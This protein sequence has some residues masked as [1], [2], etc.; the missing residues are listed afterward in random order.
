M[1]TIGK[2]DL[3]R[4]LAGSHYWA[5]WESVFFIKKAVEKSGWKAKKDTPDFI[6]ALE[7]MQVEIS[8]AGPQGCHRFLH[9]P[10]SRTERSTS[11]TRS[12]RQISRCTYRR[13]GFDQ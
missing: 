9:E 8:A 2:K 12:L 4:I 6:K 3:S 1:C 7:G 11:R 10:E 5:V 13:G